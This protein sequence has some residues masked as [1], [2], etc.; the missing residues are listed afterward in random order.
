MSDN[1]SMD[2]D[3]YIKQLEELLEQAA[4]DKSALSGKCRRILGYRNHLWTF[5]Y[6]Q[7]V[8]STNNPAERIVRQGVLWRTSSFGTQSE[9]GARYVERILTVEY[10]REACSCHFNVIAA[11]L[12]EASIGM[13]IGGY[14]AKFCKEQNISYQDMTIELSRRIETDL[15]GSAPFGAKPSSTARIEAKIRLG[16]KLS[17]QQQGILQAADNCHI[18]KSIEHGMQ[19]A[20]SLVMAG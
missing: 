6:D 3:E 16:A 1:Y 14:V 18:T 9:R 2:K 20:C 12:F 4:K 17:K 7:R 5:V 11:Q 19:I 15:S 10:L 13:C 8:D